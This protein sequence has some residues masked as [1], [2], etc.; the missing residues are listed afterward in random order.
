MDSLI[1]LLISLINSMAVIIVI[2]YVITRSQFYTEILEKKLTPVNKLL[3]VMIFGTFSIYG[4][5]SGIKVFDAIANIRDLGPAIAGLIGGPWVGLGA[6]LIGAA[7]RFL[8][9]GFT[10]MA[11]S[12]ATIVAGVMAGLVYKWRKG[13]F[14]GVTG[15]VILA[16]VVE[17]V[18]MGLTLLFSRPFDQAVVVVRTVIGPMV[19]ANAL[20]MG[21]FAFIIANLMKERAT[22]A[23][24]RQIEGELLVARDIQMSIVP[25]I[26]PPFPERSEFEVNAILEPAKEVGGDFYDFFFIDDEHLFFVI[27]DVSGKGVPASLFMAVTKTLFRAEVNR[28]TGPQDVMFRVNNA[29]CR[30][31]DTGMFVTVFCGILDTRTGQIQYA[32]GGHNPPYVVR[33]NGRIE[34]LSAGGV[35]LGVI[36]EVSY[37]L[38]ELVLEIGEQLVMFTDG[39]TEAMDKKGN[40]FTDD[41]LVETLA[42]HQETSAEETTGDVL[43]AVRSFAAGAAQSD[44]IT[45]LVL[46]YLKSRE[47]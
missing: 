18:H 42:N 45:I 27:G 22:E 31:N 3:L 44:D 25:R 10:C 32:N 1:E 16:I 14:V 21:V 29:L 35:A 30:D 24:K 9:G 43:T 46:K 34:N 20:G 15:A 37:K 8:Q 47:R 4:T 12:T 2:A 26:F 5:L 40:L 39:V 23:E 33:S 19:V 13:K 17:L 6:G 28:D 7:H 36:E 41:R 38:V 11:C